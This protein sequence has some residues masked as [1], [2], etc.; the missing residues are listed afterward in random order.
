MIFSRFMRAAAAGLCVAA[1]SASAQAPASA[2]NGCELHF[3][4]TDDALANFN[5]MLNPALQKGVTTGN[6]LLDALPAEAQ[7][8]GLERL[9][10][11]NL[12]GMPGVRVVRETQPVKDK[13]A[14]HHKGRLTASTTPCYAELAV[15]RMGY[16]TDP[17][18]GRDFGAVFIYRRFASAAASARIVQGAGDVSVKIFPP[19]DETQRDAAREEM[20]AAFGASF[21]KFAR[22]KLA[23]SAP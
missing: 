6:V 21:E 9:D 5:L 1:A 19:R 14:A 20:T 22:K 3:W 10:L 12:L 18:F 7:A 4:A 11:A 15:K 23:A 17:F 8:A 16:R 13:V 2:D